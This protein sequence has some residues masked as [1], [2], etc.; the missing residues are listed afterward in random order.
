MSPSEYAE[1][2]EFLGKKFDRIDHRFDKIDQRFER[3]EGEVRGVRVLVEE[4]A[5]DIRKVAEGVGANAERLDRFQEEVRDGFA[6]VR[7]EMKAGFEAVHTRVDRLEEN[8]D[9]AE[10]VRRR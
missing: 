10:S 3:V 4:N 2:V 7:G 5:S 6:N 8:L 9:R 1:M